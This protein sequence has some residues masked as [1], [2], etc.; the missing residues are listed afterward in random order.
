MHNDRQLRLLTQAVF[1]TL[2]ETPYLHVGFSLRGYV[3]DFVSGVFYLLELL[4][5]KGSEAFAGAADT[6][7]VHQQ[8]RRTIR[9]GWA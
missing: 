4:D 9:R 2:E 5:E 7:D 8:F 3:D 6:D 1:S